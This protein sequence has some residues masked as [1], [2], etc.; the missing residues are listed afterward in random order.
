[1]KQSE[2]S[3]RDFWANIKLTGVCITGDSAGGGR[4]RTGNLPEEQHLTD[5]LPEDAD[6]YPDAKA[7]TLPNE[8][9]QR[10]PRDNWEP[11]LKTGTE[12]Q[13]QQEKNNWSTRQPPKTTT[14][15]FSTETLQAGGTGTRLSKCSKEKPPNKNTQP[16]TLSH[17][18]EGGFSGQAKTEH[19]QA[20][21]TERLE[22]LPSSWTKG[23]Y[24]VT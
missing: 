2:D 24:S 7:Q 3:L 9:T 6:R 18:M 11:K 16:R 23:C 20:G 4:E 10:A 21:L 15:G 17:G 5:S 1:M 12:S 13:K 22:G 14:A 8:W 19:H